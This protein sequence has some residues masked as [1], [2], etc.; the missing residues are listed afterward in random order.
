MLGLVSQLLP[1]FPCPRENLKKT[2]KTKEPFLWLRRRVC[3]RAE[4]CNV[5]KVSRGW[6]RNRLCASMVV[7]TTSPIVSF[8]EGVRGA[9]EA[10]EQWACVVCECVTCECVWCVSVC[11]VCVMC[12]QLCLHSWC[13]CVWVAHQDRV[14]QLISLCVRKRWLNFHLSRHWR[15]QTPKNTALDQ[16]C[17]LQHFE[18]AANASSTN[19]HNS[20]MALARICR[21]RKWV[22]ALRLLRS[23]RPPNVN[24]PGCN[25]SCLVQQKQLMIVWI[26]YDCVVVW[27]LDHLCL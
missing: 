21:D 1:F 17:L 25:V 7:S 18:H 13:V 26:M 3:R 12:A 9:E 8:C 23:A 11:A 4:M 22:E 20:N 14:F 10:L 24:E 2:K 27:L 19:I 6:S 16:H 15:T 5:Q